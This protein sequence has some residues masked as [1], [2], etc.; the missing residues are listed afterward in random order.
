MLS[1]KEYTGLQ[2]SLKNAWSNLVSENSSK[3]YQTFSFNNIVYKHFVESKQNFIRRVRYGNKPVFAVAYEN[4]K[5]VCIAP[6][7]VFNK[8]E[9]IIRFL[10]YSTNAGYLNFI[11]NDE[12]YV[13]PMIQY[14]KAK[15]PAHNLEFTFVPD[16]SPL[17]REG[18]VIEEFG[19]YAISLSDYDSW[20]STLSKS[21]KQNIRTAYNRLK[22]DGHTYQLHLYDMNSSDLENV[23]QSA[24]DIYWRRRVDWTGNAKEYSKYNRDVFPKKDV[25]YQSLR[26]KE[27]TIIAVLRIDTQ[28][29]GFF[30]GLKYNHGICIPRLAIDMKF[31]R[32]SPWMIL[33]NEYL[34]VLAEDEFPYTFDLCRGEE[35]YKT[36][37]H[38]ERT[39]TYKIMI[40][41]SKSDIQ[42]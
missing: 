11:Y 18:G 31:S 6:L 22:T 16:N 38:A 23:I 36:S 12:S 32:Y 39:S 34:K 4:E 13:S 10:G 20:H 42:E 37:L 28:D 27:N 3:I 30:V 1:F 35:G 33:I 2:R 21:T 5:V 24:N 7:I 26:K 15:Y 40:S 8:P 25:I 17:I 29:A 14:I 9:K 19:N 41:N